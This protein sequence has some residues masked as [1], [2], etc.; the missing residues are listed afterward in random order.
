MFQLCEVRR[1]CPTTRTAIIDATRFTPSEDTSVFRWML[2]GAYE[3]V[4]HGTG[5]QHNEHAPA[6]AHFP[7][8]LRL[9]SVHPRRETRFRFLALANSVELR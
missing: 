6:T 2:G 9:A 4:V 7:T 3:T 5:E 8:P 1:F